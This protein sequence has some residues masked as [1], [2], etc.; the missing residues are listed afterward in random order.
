MLT[1]PVKVKEIFS[2]DRVKILLL[3]LL[4]FGFCFSFLIVF[5]N[6]PYGDGAVHMYLVKQMLSGS[7]LYSYYPHWVVDVID[8]T[9]VYFP[10]AYPQLDF[11]RLALAYF[12]LGE[13]G[14]K[15]S[16]VIFG[17]L[18]VL[19]VF[20]LVKQIAGEGAAFLAALFII[21]DEALYSSMVVFYMESALTLFSL[22]TV[23][24]YIKFLE[25]RGN[26]QLL[27]VSLFLGLCISSK[28][29][30]LLLYM[31]IIGFHFLYI[32]WTTRTYLPQQRKVELQRL[33]KLIAFPML[34]AAP[35]IV[36][37]L[38]TTGT[39]FYPPAPQFSRLVFPPKW[40]EDPVAFTYIEN[41]VTPDIWT[42]NWLINR[43][44]WFFVL[45]PG[46]LGFLG[47]TL[48]IFGVVWAL[49]KKR[50]IATLFSFIGLVHAIVFIWG[51]PLPRYYMILRL[52]ANIISGIGAY[53]VIQ[54]LLYS[55]RLRAV[56]ENTPFKIFA[57]K[58]MRR[59]IAVTFLLLFI[60]FPTYVRASD[61]YTE[62]HRLSDKT[63]GGRWPD[64][65]MRI[66]EAAEWLKANTL[67]PDVILVGRL[68][69]VILYL[70]RNVMWIS[71]LGGRDIPKIFSS[72]NASEAWNYLQEYRVTYV[73]IDQ[74]QFS[75]HSVDQI[76]ERGLADYIDLS[77]F[78]VKV[79]QN[80]FVKVYKV[81]IWFQASSNLSKRHYYS[82]VFG[83]Y[84]D[85]YQS[86]AVTVTPEDKW[87]L[88]ETFR[89]GKPN[90]QCYVEIKVIPEEL[91]EL[92]AT[93]MIYYKDTFNGSVDLSIRKST[94]QEDW[95][96]LATINGTNSGELRNQ[97]I[98]IE[99]VYV[100]ASK[101]ILSFSTHNEEFP[102][103]AILLFPGD[104]T[105]LEES[106][107]TEMIEELPSFKLN[108]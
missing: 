12:V 67:D 51:N 38:A 66:Q 58:Q 59:F 35:F 10:V 79:Y 17:T 70:E 91:G 52:L 43:S 72:R 105:S 82:N 103:R 104:L 16:N 63:S 93:L 32:L 25:H 1:W 55:N 97:K 88:N 78:F 44:T 46:L 90:S 85:V 71:A 8:G 86:S 15:L 42:F 106:K 77:P 100:S 65:V 56:A 101:I 76:P 50:R 107:L 30:G 49:V 69:E 83:D 75:S 2:K 81:S 19:V 74:L 41:L 96:K 33:L 11:F 36:Y 98:H 60:A 24:F 14:V 37:Q 95:Q 47:I 87:V 26:V 45:Y 29:Q 4:I 48:F 84:D 23:L 68:D 27:L 39:L 73:W 94:S 9:F 92:P 7:R 64:R 21:F 89:V 34:L 20:L 61:I 99:R 28:Q 18:S 102:M 57:S 31:G 80:D 3:G 54:T 108:R 6:A 13:T 62:Y 53:Y 40:T 22:A 5:S